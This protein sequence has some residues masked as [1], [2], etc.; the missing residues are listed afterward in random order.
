MLRKENGELVKLC[1]VRE[2]LVANG[3][4][5][6]HSFKSQ[7]VFPP[8]FNSTSPLS[9]LL[10]AHTRTHLRRSAQLE[11]ATGN[12]S[13]VHA[14]CARFNTPRPYFYILRPQQLLCIHTY[15]YPVQ[16]L[17]NRVLT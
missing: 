14:L 17:A 1:F 9:L 5:I 13:C 11:T 15:I 3:E 8:I 4:N 2:K 7:Q 10:H 6:F 16:L 12:F